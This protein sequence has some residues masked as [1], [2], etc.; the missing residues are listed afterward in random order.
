MD[1]SMD[2]MDMAKD[3]IIADYIYQHEKAREQAA[4]TI[5]IARTEKT[6]MVKTGRTVQRDLNYYPEF[7]F[8]DE[9]HA[10]IWLNEGNAD[11]LRKACAYAEREGYKVFTFPTSEPD[12]LGKAKKMAEAAS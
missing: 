2:G 8:Q 5:V 3:E 7:E 1:R 4:M 6:K 10:A 9:G 11:D 12:P